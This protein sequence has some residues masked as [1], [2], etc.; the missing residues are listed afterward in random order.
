[1]A[2]AAAICALGLSPATR[3]APIDPPTDPTP[4]APAALGNV[5]ATSADMARTPMSSYD[6][7]DQIFTPVQALNAMVASESALATRV[8]V[9]IM[10]QGGNAIDAAVAVGFAM[11]VTLPNAG[12]IGGGGFMLIHH[13]QTGADIALDFREMAPSA[14]RRDM[15]LDAQGNV[16]K[17]ASLYST[18]AVG[19]PGTVAGLL[20]ALEKYGTLPRET[21]MAPAIEL[22]RTGFPVPA[23][24]AASLAGEADHLSRWPATTRIFFTQEAPTQCAAAPCPAVPRP[25]QAGEI[26]R[27]EDLAATLSRIAEQ[28]ARGFYEGETAERIAGDI[29]RH[30]GVMTVND[31]N[32]YQAIERLPVEGTYRGN[33]VVSMPPPSSGGVHL[34]QLLNM[35]ERYPLADYG[36]GSA[37]TMH[38]MAEAMKLAYA[39]RA[40][41]M[42]DTDFVS[43][44]VAGLLSRDYAVRRGG[45]IDARR[46]TPSELVRAGNPMRFE[47]DQTTHYSVADAQ[48]NVVSTTYTLNLNFGTGMVAEGTGVLLNNEM[49]DFSVKPGVAN[50]FGLVGGQANAIAP[51]KRPL[52]SMTPVIVF[53]SGKPWM[54]TGSPGGSRIITTVLQTIVNA[55]DFGMNPAE[56]AAAPR[57][58]HQGQPDE[59]RVERGFS[60]DTT[61]LLRA[62]GHDVQV[63]PVMGRTQTIERRDRR[64][65]GASDP[66][67]PDGLTAGF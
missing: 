14:A 35:L 55:V 13:A 39:D 26:L 40:Q 12:N 62:M 1:M 42:G 63:K 45:A 19:V 48:G 50:A 57:F 46:A 32:H 41:Y 29:Q 52:S 22:A 23:S 47:S 8:G 66:R 67:N 3:A 4:S 2:L 53:R 16:I 44:P 17:G 9:D 5:P 56:S 7:G 11:A 21:V 49:D 60:P 37:Q 31:L 20:K 51:G 6:R 34:I 58:H 38:I 33:R 18:L 27:Q 15:Y 25:L 65:Y 28:G 30:G 61:R 36:F 64:F 10:R 24:L 54:V 43:V 59:L